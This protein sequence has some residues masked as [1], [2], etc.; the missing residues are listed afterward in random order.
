[1]IEAAKEVSTAVEG[2]NKACSDVTRDENLLKDMHLAS[3]QVENA[4]NELIHHI[5]TV[6][7]Q[8]AQASIHDGAVDTILDATDRLFSSTGDAGEMVRQ[9][10]ILATV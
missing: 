10:K 4:L 1:M 5:R 6:N 3:S 7:K 2:I 8:R 9:A